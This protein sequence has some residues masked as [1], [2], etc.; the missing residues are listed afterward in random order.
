MRRWRLVF[1]AVIAILL[2]TALPT[3]RQLLQE[4]RRVTVENHRLQTLLAENAV[5]SERLDRLEDPDYLEK[6]AREELGLVRPGEVSYV[7]VPPEGE[8]EEEPPPPPRPG[9]HQRVWRWL[10][11]LIRGD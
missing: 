5:L 7:V 10:T 8:A 6:L 3:A 4:R 2:V 9:W 11:G 1:L